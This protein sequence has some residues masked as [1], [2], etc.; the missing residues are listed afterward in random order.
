MTQI[1]ELPGKL[2]GQNHPGLNLVADAVREI[3]RAVN[4]M[5]GAATEPPELSEITQRLSATEQATTDLTGRVTDAESALT[6]LESSVSTLTGRVT[7]LESP[8]TTP[9]PPNAS[10]T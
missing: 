9:P 5:G 2:P 1:P 4:G 10:G 6:S 3:I 8:P 7:A